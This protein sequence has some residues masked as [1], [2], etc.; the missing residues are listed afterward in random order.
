MSLSSSSS[1]GSKKAV[2]REKILSW[3][4]EEGD[5]IF[6]IKEN[7]AYTDFH[8][9]VTS[10]DGRTSVNV[11]FYKNKIDLAV[12]VTAIKFS[13][14]DRKTYASLKIQG[15]KPFLYALESAL[16]QL[17]VVYGYEPNH[18]MLERVV[19]EKRVY[20]EALDKQK[21]FDTIHLMYRA[22]TVVSLNFSIYLSKN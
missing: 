8:L 13:A 12:F 22:S 11:I 4:K 21:F 5:Y 20:F 1:N 18:N 10:K 2:I 9:V 3:L 19:I 6:E 16:L 7:D 17:D 14:E 15:K